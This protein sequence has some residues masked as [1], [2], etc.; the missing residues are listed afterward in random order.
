MEVLRK[1][2]VDAIMSSYLTCPR[3]ND[4]TV[5]FSCLDSWPQYRYL[6][7]GVF[8]F[9][10][11]SLSASTRTLTA[12][13]PAAA[14]ESL[15]ASQRIAEYVSDTP[16]S[17][18]DL[19]AKLKLP[20]S[21]LP[22][23]LSRL[24]TAGIA[25]V[26]DDGSVVKNRYYTGYDMRLSSFLDY[27]RGYVAYLR[28]HARLWDYI[29]EVDVDAL[30]F[31]KEDGSLVSG[32]DVASLARRTL[33]GIVGSKL[34]R[35][36]HH[37]VDEPPYPLFRKMVHDLPYFCVS[38]D[39]EPDNRELRYLC[40]YAHKAGSIIHGL[41]TSKPDVLDVTPFDTADSTTWLAIQRFG[42]MKG[43]ALTWRDL[44]SHK[45]VA[46]SRRLLAM[47]EG[48]GYSLEQIFDPKNTEARI[49]LAIADIVERQNQLTLPADFLSQPNLF[50]EVAS[51]STGPT[52]P[53]QGLGPRS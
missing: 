3:G 18:K 39:I 22:I 46:R 45:E 17:K 19:A 48:H 13:M 26:R 7:S 24:H 27:F 9:L 49:D 43:G 50:E 44:S 30:K 40:D 35:V 29:V 10:R 42:K 41:G 38:S 12:S 11:Y 37:M 4:A 2:K 23:A 21:R 31:G 36:W 51:A 34:L 47:A 8:T 5:F 14:R 1:N 32:V 53:D 15:K 52:T 6:D 33:E 16:I 20:L 25:T 28:E